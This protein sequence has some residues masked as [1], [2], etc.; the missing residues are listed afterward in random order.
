MNVGEVV[1]FLTT[2]ARSRR[3]GLSR[4]HALRAE[5]PL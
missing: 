5:K 2:N 1:D 4:L 3:L